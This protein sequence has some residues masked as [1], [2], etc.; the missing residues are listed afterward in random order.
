MRI[1]YFLILLF[2]FVKC[3]Y[4]ILQLINKRLMLVI[5]VNFD[6]RFTL[7][8]FKSG[9]QTKSHVRKKKHNLKMNKKNWYFLIIKPKLRQETSQ[10]IKLRQGEII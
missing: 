10:N 3:I 1:N 4:L 6:I 8:K 9:D 2:L 7:Q 5:N